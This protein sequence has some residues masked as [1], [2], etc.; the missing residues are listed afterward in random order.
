[1]SRST[2]GGKPPAR[3]Q[4]MLALGIRVPCPSGQAHAYRMAETHAP[5]F[6][7]SGLRASLP[8]G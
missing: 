7:V 6:G 1:M 4:H 2:A 5:V 3:G 8:P